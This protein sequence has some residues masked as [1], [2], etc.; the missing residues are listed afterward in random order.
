MYLSGIAL[1][2][3]RLSSFIQICHLFLIAIHMMQIVY[4]ESETFECDKHSTVSVSVSQ[5]QVECLVDHVCIIV[6]VI[7]TII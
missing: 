4:V 1:W 5:C 2:V 7:E 3:S 6:S